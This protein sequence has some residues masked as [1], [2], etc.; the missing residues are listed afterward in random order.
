MTT[1]TPLDQQRHLVR[2]F[3]TADRQR[4]ERETT[5]QQQFAAGEKAATEQRTASERTAQQQYA[6]AEKSAEQQYSA[7][8]KQADD[9]K[10]R[11]Q[12]QIQDAISKIDHNW[13]TAVT[14]LGALG[15]PATD[16]P[17][18]LNKASPRTPTSTL[19]VQPHDQLQADAKQIIWL[20][21]DADRLVLAYRRQQ[22][23]RRKLLITAAVVALLLAVAGY[24]GFQ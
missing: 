12:Y 3:V 6:T 10:I 22:A 2:S 8:I 13:S 23:L 17:L 19:G 20:Y 15:V 4:R 21:R 16:L 5:A 14:D 11:Q 9:E 24:F 7:A 1:P 18:Q